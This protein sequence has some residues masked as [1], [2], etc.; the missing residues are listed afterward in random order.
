MSE[1]AKISRVIP[2]GEQQAWPV[3]PGTPGGPDASPLLGPPVPYGTPNP[4]PWRPVTPPPPPPA[5]P[6]LPAAPPPDP[7][8]IEVR[9]TVD[10]IGPQP[11]PEP[12]RR[13]WS[14]LTS[15]VR[16]WA[17]LISG[18]V[19]LGPWFGGTSAVGAWSRAMHD[20]RTEAGI[21]PAYII[22]GTALAIAFYADD[23]RPRWWT[24]GA[25]LVALVGGTGAMAWF[26]PVTALTG[27]RP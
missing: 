17:S 6:W 7:G 27:V 5:A 11:E 1:P 8:P 9:V 4:P 24:R 13:D 25:L 3:R 26:D 12:E 23:R 18:V 19:V 21:L 2:S 15:R 22:A 16:P 14:W 10:L 20:A